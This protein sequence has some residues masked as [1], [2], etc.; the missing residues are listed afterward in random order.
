MKGNARKPRE[1]KRYGIVGHQQRRCL[2]AL[3]EEIANV[4]V[5]GWS[6]TTQK[7]VNFWRPEDLASGVG[8][9]PVE[10]CL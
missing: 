8:R 4:S 3:D 2:C 1:R 9:S 10:K 7:W 5:D 6:G